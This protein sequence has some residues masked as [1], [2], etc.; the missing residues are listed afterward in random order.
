M[1]IK[2]AGFRYIPKGAIKVADKKSDA[3]AYFYNTEI[4]GTDRPAVR[5]FF[6]KQA[7]PVLACWFAPFKGKSGEQQRA[8]RVANYFDSRQNTIDYK[9]K[10]QAEKKAQTRGVEVGQFMS[11]SWGYEQ[12]NVNFYK[13]TKLIGETMAEVVAVGQMDVGGEGGAAMSTNVIPMEE[14][15]ADAKTYKV[16]VKAGRATINGNYASVWDGKPK[17]CS[18]YA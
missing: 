12:T 8:E 18:W 3:V 5:I 7:K 2:A 10:R 14:P 16:R 11:A 6:G 17:Y 1:T 9:A 4:N 13:V 15:K